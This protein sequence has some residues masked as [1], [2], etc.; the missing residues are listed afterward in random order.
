MS[1]CRR[2]G[3]DVPA[4]TLHIFWG[5]E[6]RRA[7]LEKLIGR[8]VTLCANPLSEAELQELKT[9][10]TSDGQGKLVPLP[11]DEN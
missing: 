8:P 2:C 10:Y 7:K 3:Q 4:N 5:G 6:E 9:P 1:E 11:I